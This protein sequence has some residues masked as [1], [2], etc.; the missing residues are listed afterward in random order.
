MI[1][2]GYVDFAS[3]VKYIA[4]VETGSEEEGSWVKM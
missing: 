1:E 2:K 3:Y 4:K